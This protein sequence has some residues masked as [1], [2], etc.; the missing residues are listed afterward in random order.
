[1]SVENQEECLKVTLSIKVP[2]QQNVFCALCLDPLSHQMHKT[3]WQY[4]EPTGVG[5]FDC[6]CCFAYEIKSGNF[7]HNKCANIIFRRCLDHA[8]WNLEFDEQG[9]YYQCICVHKRQNMNNV[10]SARK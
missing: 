5:L 9:C 1:M 2:N 8:E 10:K 7:Y 3:F 6:S 4:Q